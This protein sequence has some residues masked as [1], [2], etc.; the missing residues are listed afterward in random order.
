MENRGLCNGH[1]IVVALLVSALAVPCS[2][3]SFSSGTHLSQTI[4]TPTATEYDAGATTAT[5]AATNFSV[6]ISVPTGGGSNPHYDL[7]LA[8]GTNLQGQ[9][10]DIQWQIVSVSNATNCGS[11]AVGAPFAEISSLPILTMGKNSS[12]CTVTIAF[13]VAGLSYAVQDVGAGGT[14]ANFAQNVVFTVTTR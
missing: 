2:A 10:L 14:F 9:L 6:T 13:R 1:S 11:P 8:R 5:P 4:T 7:T 12:P 3:Q